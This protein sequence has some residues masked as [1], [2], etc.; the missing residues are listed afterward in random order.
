MCPRLSNMVYFSMASG[1][2]QF[3]S[4]FWLFTKKFIR[5]ELRLPYRSSVLRKFKD[6]K[7]YPVFELHLSETPKYFLSQIRN[8]FEILDIGS[9]QKG[10]RNRE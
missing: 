9:Q 6:C 8:S 2:K 1:E 5:K 10:T 4:R 3:F 7:I